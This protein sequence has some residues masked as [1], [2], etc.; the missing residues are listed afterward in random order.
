MKRF[1]KSS[2]EL[3]ACLQPR[4]RI[5]GRLLPH[6]LS[7]VFSNLVLNLATAG[8]ASSP[9]GRR[10]PQGQ[11]LLPWTPP[12]SN[13]CLNYLVKNGATGI[14][15]ISR[16]LPGE[17]T[18]RNM[19][20]FPFKYISPSTTQSST[21]T[22]PVLWQQRKKCLCPDKTKCTTLALRER[23][24]IECIPAAIVNGNPHEARRMARIPKLTAQR[25]P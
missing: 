21:L 2:P 4:V 14:P 16:H 18:P 8:P 10:E 12:P 1:V 5:S 23:K 6:R 11:W 24:P 17:P 13:S 7:G 25:H 22:N 15:T 9:A 20:F 19:D 3:A